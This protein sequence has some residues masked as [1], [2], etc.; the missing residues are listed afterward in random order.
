MI[1][2]YYLRKRITFHAIISN[3]HSD[4]RSVNTFSGE[5]GRW[6]TKSFL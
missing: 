3:F 2:D 5:L 6:F 1:I 4:V